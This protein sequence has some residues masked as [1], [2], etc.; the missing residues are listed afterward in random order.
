MGTDFFD[1]K[2]K[3]CLTKSLGKLIVLPLTPYCKNIIIR[4]SITYL[5]LN[6]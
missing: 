5:K 4:L 2:K 6:N 1:T 3:N